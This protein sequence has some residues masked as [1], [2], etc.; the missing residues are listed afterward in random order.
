M[1]QAL[2][3]PHV[4][5]RMR[6]AVAGQP[7]EEDSPCVVALVYTAALRIVAVHSAVRRSGVVPDAS[8]LSSPISLYEAGLTLAI[9][10]H[11]GVGDREAIVAAVIEA[12]ALLPA[13]TDSPLRHGKAGVRAQSWSATDRSDCVH[14]RPRGAGPV[15]STT[16]L[17]GAGIVRGAGRPRA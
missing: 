8:V 2:C 11:L 1:Q 4:I 6:T 15:A 14:P 7:T 12:L 9:F 3:R 16:D 13:G 17:A 10:L 5:A